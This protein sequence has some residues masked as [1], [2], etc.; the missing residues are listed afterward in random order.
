MGVSTVEVAAKRPSAGDCPPSVK[1][2]IL[3]G[4]RIRE[5]RKLRQWKKAVSLLLEAQRELLK[6]NMILYCSAI[7]AC[8][9]CNEWRQALVLLKDTRCQWLHANTFTYS[10]SISACEKAARWREAFELFANARE[11]SHRELR[12]DPMD[13]LTD[14]V[15]HSAVTS[16]CEKSSQWQ[17][18][19]QFIHLCHARHLEVSLVTYNAG[20]SACEK[21]EM[22]KR[23]GAAWRQ[24][25]LLIEDVEQ[26]R[27]QKDTILF[28]AAISAC[29]KAGKLQE[30]LQLLA[31]AKTL[32]LCSVNVYGAAIG[33]C[34][35]AAESQWD[36]ALHLLYEMKSKT[37][38]GNV[39][40]YSSA[41]SSC[42]KAGKWREAVQL[43]ADFSRKQRQPPSGNKLWNFGERWS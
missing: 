36:V 27:F 25:L 23:K 38:R 28:G 13:A 33:A 18:A 29:K 5:C 12:P 11:A 8:E 9:A 2:S 1:A 17:R 39:I 37:L 7:S 35:S 15:T 34:E 30:A 16:A 31:E 21:S 19:L 41:A 22:S 40:T 6:L 24:A 14:T 43:L 3:L 20:I 4:K 42:A 10:S 32:H 26:Q